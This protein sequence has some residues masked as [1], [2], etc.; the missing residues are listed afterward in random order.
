MKKTP[1]P[2]KKNNN[3][4]GEVIELGVDVHADS[5]V[6]VAKVDASSPERARKMSPQQFLSWVGQVRQNCARLYCCYE[7]GPF[8]FGLH[9]Q[10]LELEVTNYVIRPINWDEQGKNTKTDK[11]DAT[12]M[13][14]ALDGYL[15]GNDRSFSVV[16]VPREE[17]ERRRSLS[18]Q[19]Q[20]LMKERNRLAAKGRSHVLYYGGRLKGT[21]WQPRRWEKLCGVLAS[22]LMEL[23]EPLRAVI[24]AVEEQLEAVITKLESGPTPALPKGMGRTNFEQL[25]REVVGLEMKPAVG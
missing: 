8:G 6:I 24:L 10:L 12:Q 21:W 5:Y 23:L 22:F 11:R 9:R 7:A 14:L 20:S 13:V 3:L 18:R 17:E 15:R 1:M 16:R 2:S 4:I 19:R 25:E